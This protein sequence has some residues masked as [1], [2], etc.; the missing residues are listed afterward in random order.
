KIELLTN[1]FYMAPV[2]DQSVT[3]AI[4]GTGFVTGGGWV[5]EPNLGTRSNFGFTVKYLK[6]GNIQGNSLYIYRQ[7]L[8]LKALYPTLSVPS[9][10]RAYNWVIKSNSMTGLTE[11]CTTTQPVVCTATFTG[12]S[13]ITAVDRLTG[14]AY[15]LGGNN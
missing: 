9:G 11:S 12:K 2:E 1:G 6:N 13:T 5:N 4:A 15:S 3:V 8:D 14:I 7:T 10:V